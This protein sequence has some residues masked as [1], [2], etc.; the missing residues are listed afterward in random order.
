[1]NVLFFQQSPAF[2][3][4]FDIVTNQWDFWALRYEL[5][6]GFHLAETATKTCLDTAAKVTMLSIV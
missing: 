5:W 4:N 2:I 6:D 3:K 1:M